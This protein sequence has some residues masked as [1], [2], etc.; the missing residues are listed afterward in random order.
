MFY[1]SAHTGVIYD[2]ATKTQRLLQGHCNRIT[3]TACSEDKRWIVTADDG[4]DSML[5][6][7]DSISGTPIRTY[8]NPHPNGVK[9]ID[10]SADNS[11]LATLGNDVPQT[12]SLWDWT[13]EKE[14]G[15]IVS[16]QFKVTWEFKNQHWVKFNP[17]N[18]QEIAANGK[19]RVLFLSW[20][21]GVPTFQYYSPRI[22]KKDFSGKDKSEAHFTK[23]VFIPNKEMAVTGTNAGDLLVWDRSLIIEGIGEQNE[24]RLIKIV[25]LN[26]NYSPIN[27]LMTVHDQ[28]L[29]CGNSDGTIR[30]YDFA[31]KV[32]AWFEELNLSTVKSISFSRTDP[33]PANTMG[34]QEYQ[35]TD[36][37]GEVVDKS[38]G[39]ACSDFLVTDDSAL[40]CM[41]QSSIFEEIEP[42]KKKGYTIFHGLKS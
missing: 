18:P 29:V 36:E 11:Y 31:F 26:A 16:L 39:F 22:E 33:K 37:N 38:S 40:V 10:I 8:L 25:P 35:Q 30:F 2:Y 4:E 23:T 19:E 12:I 9:T 20:E 41:L 15:P 3:A 17:G 27:M 7:W 32:V 13:N 21:P 14:E 1:S 24:K 34:H 6:V 42:S 28:F 5:V